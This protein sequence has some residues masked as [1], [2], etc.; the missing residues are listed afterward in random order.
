MADDLGQPS[1]APQGLG[2]SSF[3]PPPPPEVT[4]APPPK[5]PSSSSLQKS[6][7]PP[8]P[9]ETP[10]MLFEEE[11]KQGGMLKSFLLGFIVILLLGGLGLGTWWYLGFNPPE[12]AT[13]PGPITTPPPDDVPP[14]V[15]TDA[16]L[17]RVDQ[18]FTIELSANAT[19]RELF[20][21]LSS[22]VNT[23]RDLSSQDLAR[24]VLTKNNALLTFAEF[25]AL[26]DVDFSP[27]VDQEVFTLLYSP[28]QSGATYGL[29]L[30]IADEG[31]LG[32]FFASKEKDIPFLA[33]DLYTSYTTQALPQASTEEFLENTYQGVRIRYINFGTP[34]RSFDYAL[35]QDLLLL[36]GS[37]GI[38]FSLIDR[39]KLT[40]LLSGNR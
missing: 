17:L 7:T 38:T 9:P 37:R 23:T 32:E 2:S 18:S 30:K 24:I 40:S 36:G 6:S 35:Y 27:Y 21:K 31:K 12:D 14:V 19:R 8:L 26:I 33:S 20:Q 5:P 16:P 11:P 22:H 39:A 28:Q 29:V 34:D 4:S 10:E 13:P 25:E 15:T 3:T 1:K